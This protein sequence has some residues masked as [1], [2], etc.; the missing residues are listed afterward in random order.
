MK[1]IK[2]TDFGA[3]HNALNKMILGEVKRVLELVPE[4]WMEGPSLCRIVVSKDGDYEPKD[5]AVDTV[6]LHEDKLYFDGHIMPLPDDGNVEP[7]QFDGGEECCTDWLDITDFQY[8]IEQAK[9]KIPAEALEKADPISLTHY[10]EMN[11]VREALEKTIE[12]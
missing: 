12:Y 8:L 10:G 9:D 2:T 5:V 11:A 4:K 1:K 6:W 7:E 3:I